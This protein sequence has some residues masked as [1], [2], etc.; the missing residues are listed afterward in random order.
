MNLALGTLVIFLLLVPGFAFLS[1]YHSGKY[2]RKYTRRNIFEDFTNATVPALIIH[3][4]LGGWLFKKQISFSALGFLLMGAS[5]NEKTIQIFEQNI[6]NCIGKIL[7]YFF[8]SS[9]LGIVSGFSAAK[10]VRSKKWDFK[11]DSLRFDNEWYYLFSGEHTASIPSTL[12]TFENI[13]NKEITV[14]IKAFCVINETFITY[15]GVIDKFHLNKDG[16]E[17]IYLKQ[18]WSKRFS[19]NV[20]IKG[21]GILVLLAKDVFSMAVYCPPK[22]E[23]KHGTAEEVK[24]KLEGS[25]SGASTVTGTATDATIS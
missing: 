4:F 23:I 1:S 19:D 21:K 3:A 11:F 22:G 5:N 14:F 16:L 2:S 20:K 17:S 15:H 18:G 13:K 8:I 24:K 25:L 6:G 12:V 7:G 9:L 10:L